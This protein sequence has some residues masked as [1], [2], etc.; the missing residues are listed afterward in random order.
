[1]L[2]PYSDAAIAQVRAPRVGAARLS[3]GGMSRRRQIDKIRY[4]FAEDCAK[5]FCAIERF[6]R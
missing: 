4:K 3:R 5:E 2:I 6:L 1:M